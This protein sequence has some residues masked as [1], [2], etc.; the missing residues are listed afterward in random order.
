M[1]G[2]STAVGLGVQREGIDHV[3]VAIGVRSISGAPGKR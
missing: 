2:Q 3:G 1:S